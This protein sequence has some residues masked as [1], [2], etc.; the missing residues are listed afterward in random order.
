M[1]ST[2]PTQAAYLTP[3]TVLAVEGSNNRVAVDLLLVQW[4]WWSAGSVLRPEAMARQG[5]QNAGP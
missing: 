1:F 3:K 2:L 4:D 5:R